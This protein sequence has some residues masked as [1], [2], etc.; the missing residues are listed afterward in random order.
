MSLLFPFT[1]NESKIL[2]AATLNMFFDLPLDI[3]QKIAKTVKREV[4]DV[5]D[6]IESFSN[7]LTKLCST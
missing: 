3:Q 2:D 5:K 7:N 1:I 6:L 4:D